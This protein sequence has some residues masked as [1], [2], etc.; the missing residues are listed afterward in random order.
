MNNIVYISEPEG[1]SEI[2]KQSLRNSGFEIIENLI[3]LD[4]YRVIAVFV[5]LSVIIDQNYLRQFPN[6][7]FIVSPTTGLSHID[8]SIFLRSDITIISLKN[9]T[10]ALL[11]I[12][13]T[14]EL[15]FGLMIN[16][17]RGINLA[18]DSVRK[19]IWNR[20]L[21]ISRQLYRKKVGIIGLGR[22]GNMMAR[23]CLAFGMEICYYDIEDKNNEYSKASSICEVFET[24]NVVS[25]HI[26]ENPET[27]HLIN[28]HVLEKANG[29][30]L[31]NTSRS[32][33]VD[34][35]ALHKALIKG[36]ILTYSADVLDHEDQGKTPKTSILLRP[37]HSGRV[38]I[39]PHMGGACFEAMRYT[40][41]YVTNLFLRLYE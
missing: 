5:R 11:H 32:S 4:H 6:V 27:R 38:F 15:A 20:N 21:F 9:D 33:V 1:F 17:Y 23:Y 37:E 29:V 28:S 8:A 3:S 30:H 31:V 40:E 16:A 13:G 22:L 18:I 35:Y 34:H 36:K 26:P 25:I 19:D 2:A 10:D 7:K 24:C 14:A 41:E 12:T 39:T